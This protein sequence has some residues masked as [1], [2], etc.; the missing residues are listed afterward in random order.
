MRHDNRRLRSEL[1]GNP[2][3]PGTILQRPRKQALLDERRRDLAAA[4]A[5]LALA[6]QAARDGSGEVRALVEAEH[7]VGALETVVR[8]LEQDSLEERE[9]ECRAT[10]KE[11]LAA[12]AEAFAKDVE[13]VRTAEQAAATAAADTAAKIREEASKR[14]ALAQRLVAVS[15]LR[16][17]WPELDGVALPATP[18]AS[19]HRLPVYEAMRRLESAIDDARRPARDLVVA[20]R[21]NADATERRRDEMVGLQRFL[22]LH[23]AAIPA[24]VAQILAA[25]TP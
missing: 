25:A 1:R 14:R 4:R 7:L 18:D 11:W 23:A 8:D 20:H 3:G 12:N 6:R 5:G 2:N 13:A 21:A 9:Q 19:D 17:R 15:A 24:E 16:L 22:G 10:A